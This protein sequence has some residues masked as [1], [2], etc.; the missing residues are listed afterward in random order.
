[1]KLYIHSNDELI[2][3]EFSKRATITPIDKAEA[4]FIDW[5]NKSLMKYFE[6]VSKSKQKFII[7]DRN[8]SI[9][10]GESNTLRQKGAILT[11]PALNFRRKYFHYLPYWV[12]IK[13]INEIKLNT[14]PRT[15]DLVFKGPIQDKI[16]SFN[17]Y[18]IPYANE[19]PNTVV[20]DDNAYNNRSV[21]KKDFNFSECKATLII[22]SEDDYKI[23][24]LDYN[25]I[26]AL[27]NNCVPLIVNESKYFSLLAPYRMNNS[28][29]INYIVSNYETSYIGW[30]LGV[31]GTI[32]IFYPEMIVENVVQQVLELV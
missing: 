17:K 28:F 3:D 29:D 2:K 15:H 20:V 32:K 10:P 27:N 18:Y 11:E 31:Y 21:V 9:S 12:K 16:T 7:F 26:E 30:L 4:I 19:Y 6:S 5:Q 22:G 25:F 23:G 13:D 24:Y 14:A 1:M 8:L